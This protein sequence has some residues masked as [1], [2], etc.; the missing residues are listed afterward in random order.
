MGMTL[1]S[2]CVAPHSNLGVLVLAMM[3]LFWDHNRQWLSADWNPCLAADAWRLVRIA[4]PVR[5]ASPG[6]SQQFSIQKA[7]L[8]V[9]F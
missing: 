1:V 4:P 5:I 2:R 8:N 7:L 6:I 3:K 9:A